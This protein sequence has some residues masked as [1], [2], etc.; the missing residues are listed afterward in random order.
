VTGDRED[1][2]LTLT[3]RNRVVANTKARCVL[4]LQHF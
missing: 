2:R 1:D 4:Q 3:H